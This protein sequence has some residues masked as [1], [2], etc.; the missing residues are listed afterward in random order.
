MTK[1]Q[2]DDA[3]SGLVYTLVVEGPPYGTESASLAYLFASEAVKEHSVRAV[4]FYADGVLNA[5]RGLS[6][7]ND[8]FNLVKAWQKFAKTHAVRL[9]LCESAGMRR[10]V[11]GPYADEG[12]EIG[13]LSDLA[14]FTSRSDRT[15]QFK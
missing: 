11:T 2:I 12:F 9:V 1:Q 6:P 15:V 5:C 14:V 8:E 7:A 10:A 3:P 13:S 4:F